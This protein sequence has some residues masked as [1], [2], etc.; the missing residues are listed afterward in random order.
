METPA[1]PWTVR[2]ASTISDTPTGL[3]WDTEGL[4]VITYGFHVYAFEARTGVLRWSHRSGSPIVVVLASSRLPHVLVQAEVETFALEPDGQVGWR[5]THSD[6]VA[7]AELV[8]GQLVLTSF[9]GQVRALEARTG[10][11]AG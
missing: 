1:G 5:A 2:L 3:L 8:G 9:A 4:L 7:G 10:R 6:V 11:A